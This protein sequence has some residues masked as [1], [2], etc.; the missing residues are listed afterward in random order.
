MKIKIEY[1]EVL[2]ANMEFVLFFSYNMNIRMVI[3]KAVWRICFRIL[4]EIFGLGNNQ[5]GDKYLF[6]EGK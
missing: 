6:K 1:K 5:P 4:S 3:A 2:T